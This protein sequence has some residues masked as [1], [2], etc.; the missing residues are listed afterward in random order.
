MELVPLRLKVRQ[1]AGA[2]DAQ[3]R[4]F[5]A[6][7]YPDLDAVPSELRGGVAWQAFIDRFGTHLIDNCCEF[8]EVDDYNTEHGMKYTGFLV[9]PEFADSAV[10]RFPDQC[11]ILSETEWEEFH[12]HRVTCH[13][14]DEIVDA[15]TLNAIRAKHGIPSGP[16]TP[17]AAMTAAERKAIDPND[18]TP[19]V[20]KNTRKYWKDVKAKRQITIRAKPKR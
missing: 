11:E 17:T 20:V 13:M 12:D 2:P 5:N 9:P 6:W 3:G 19:G 4:V 7:L 8:H 18:P 10:A 16:L 1:G 15:N 14:P